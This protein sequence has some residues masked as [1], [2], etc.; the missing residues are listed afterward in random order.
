[1]FDVA[2]TTVRDRGEVPAAFAEAL[3]GAGIRVDE[4]E[5]AA[6][7]GASK[8]DALTHLVAQHD[9]S[10]SGPERAAK[11]AEL[12]QRFRS[13]LTRRLESTS[14]LSMPEAVATF[15]RLKRAGIRI[16]L[17]SGF[18]RAIMDLIL[19]RVAWPAGL[20]DVVVCGE[21]VARGRPAPD[22]I[23]QSME[24]VGVR[25][26]GLVAVVGDTRLDL[27]AGA[28]AGV[29]YRIGVLSGAHDRATLE[30]APCTHLVESI[31]A[32]PDIWGL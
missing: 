5:I 25:D 29:R 22:M 11:V 19:A 7:R 6:W 27:E 31:G 18:D 14:G 24:R 8:R 26:A 9:E 32:V 23:V 3:A 20:L 16:G 17:N 1:V 2:G 13:G 10:L 4:R 28:N 15:Q 12:Y 30:R 21:D